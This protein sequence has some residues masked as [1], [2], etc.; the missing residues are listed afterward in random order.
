MLKKK[1]NNKNSTAGDPSKILKNEQKKKKNKK[2]K[3]NTFEFLLMY[4]NWHIDFPL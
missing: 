2:M 1:I 4:K 3:K